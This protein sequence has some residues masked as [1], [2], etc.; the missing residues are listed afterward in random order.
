MFSGPWAEAWARELNSS[1]VYRS[2]ATDWDGTL[3]FKLKA[4]DPSQ[5]RCIFLELQGGRCEVARLATEQDEQQAQFVLTAKE[6]VWK[7]LVEG[8]TEPLVMLMTGLIRFERGR[9]TDFAGHGKA[10]QELMR[11]A[12]RI[13]GSS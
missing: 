10:A 4:R 11:A 2:A 1:E 7:K 5:E 8:R 3:C 12:Q 6:R 13:G 9:L